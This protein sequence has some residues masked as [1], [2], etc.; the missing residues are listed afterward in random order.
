MAKQLSD[1]EFLRDL[2]ALSSA[3]EER[4][5]AIAAR[6]DQPPDVSAFNAGVDMAINTLLAIIGPDGMVNALDIE[7]ARGHAKRVGPVE[8]EPSDPIASDPPPIFTPTETGA[9]PMTLTAEQVRQYEARAAAGET[10][11]LEHRVRWTHDSDIPQGYYEVLFDPPSDFVREP[12]VFECPNELSDFGAIAVSLW[13][14]DQFAA[15]AAP[16]HEREVDGPWRAAFDDH[17][18]IWWSE[19]PLDFIRCDD[20]SEARAIANVRNAHHARRQ[21]KEAGK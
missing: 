15:F 21:A 9:K 17:T 13:A 19:G 7:N 12:L 2:Y 8:Q 10:C 1:A 5:R 14:Q 16:L 4:I 3:V 6:Q 11:V 18:D 20:A